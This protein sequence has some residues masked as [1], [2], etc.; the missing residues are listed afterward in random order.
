MDEAVICVH[1]GC[2]QPT[3]RMQTQ[4][5]EEKELK[6]QRDLQLGK[7]LCMIAAVLVIIATVWFVSVPRTIST[8]FETDNK[9]YTYTETASVAPLEPIIFLVSGA[10]VALGL[11]A[12]FSKSNSTRRTL[13]IVNLVVASIVAILSFLYMFQPVGVVYFINVLAC[14]LDIIVA[15]KYMSIKE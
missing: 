11:L 10:V 9:K 2:A 3:M 12:T 8:S 5:K 15:V 4:S 6:N 14:V 1:C 13:A 7:V